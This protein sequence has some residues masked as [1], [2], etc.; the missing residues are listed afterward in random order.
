MYYKIK[1]TESEVYNKLHK[2]RTNEIRIE[3]DNLLKIQEKTG[4]K[5]DSFFGYGG[6][7]C[8]PRVTQY[9]GFKFKDPSKVNMKIWKEHKEHKNVF[10]PNKRTKAGKEIAELLSN[11]L[12]SSSFCTVFDIL[13]IGHPV[14]KFV[15]PYVD[16]KGDL[17]VMYL[18]DS[19]EPNNDDIIEITKAEALSLINN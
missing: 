16:I 17:I 10:I 3:K 7:Q 14:G 2:M 12:E 9:K 8:Y 15:F 19:H 6:Q 18:D 1:N 5:W 4:L 13:E 11:G